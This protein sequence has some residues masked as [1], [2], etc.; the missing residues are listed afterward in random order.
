LD[1]REA[2]LTKKSVVNISQMFT[3]NKSDLEEKIG[4]LGQERLGEV[5]MGVRLI[6]EPRDIDIQ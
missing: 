1:K 3:V 4:T 2:N 6:T 5:L